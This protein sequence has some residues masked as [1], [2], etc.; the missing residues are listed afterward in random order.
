MAIAEKVVLRLEDL[1]TWITVDAEWTWGRIAQCD[2]DDLE[3]KCFEDEKKKSSSIDS[4]E[5]SF[6]ILEIEKEKISNGKSKNK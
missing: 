5:H 6:D 1:V 2:K 3:P 4:I